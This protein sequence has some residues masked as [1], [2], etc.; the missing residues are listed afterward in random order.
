MTDGYSTDRDAA[1]RFFD[2]WEVYASIVARDLMHHRAIFRA[3]RGWTHLHRPGPFTLADLGCGD[4]GFVLPTFTDTALWRYT[5]VD[6]SRG[7]LD[8]AAK[9][10]AGARFQ[11]RLVEADMLDWLR[12]AGAGGADTGTDVV[13][14]LFSVHHLP[15]EAKRTFFE[16]ANA[17]LAPGGTLLFGDMFRRAQES[18]AAWADAFVAMMRVE[19]SGLPPEAL[20]STIDHL[21]THDHPETVADLNAIATA[22]GFAP[23]PHDLFHDAAGFYRLL[24]FTKPAR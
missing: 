19:W 15:S 1:P 13:L 20:A 2:G 12:G 6:A 22:A 23:A 16:R 5:G 8:V 18:R 9:N 17:A 21:E 10:L 7:A 11:T 24:G 14:S 4:C 3:I